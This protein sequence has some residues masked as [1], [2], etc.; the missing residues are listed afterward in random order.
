MKVRTKPRRRAGLI[1]RFKRSDKVAYLLVLP[2]LVQFCVFTAFPIGFAIELTFHSWNL[3]T[4]DKPF[5]GLDNYQYI[6]TVEPH[7]RQSLL[8]LG[9]YVV[10][11]VPGVVVISMLFAI[12]L[13]QDIRFRS[14]FRIVYFLPVVVGGV[15]TL[16]LFRLVLTSQGMLN[17][18]LEF[19][20]V[21]NPPHWFSDPSWA[22]PGFAIIGIWGAF[23]FSTIIFL[24]ALQNI[25]TVLHEAAKMDGARLWQEIRYITVPLLNPTI[26]L[27]VI[28]STIGALQLFAQP[29]ILTGGGPEGSTRT[30][31]I[32]LFWTAFS[33]LEMGRAATIGFLLSLIILTIALIER[34]VL[35]RP[36][37]V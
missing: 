15:G 22:M 28:V 33:Y 1:S 16:L 27:I 9:R 20:G 35:R 37:H 5:V 25:P 14:L 32:V 21:R 3:M 17:S 30:P 2:Y 24:A 36:V 8:N 18:F 7:F 19:V 31:V 29:Y 4:P 26:I 11:Q 6:M 23:G 12:L 10:I 13:N 34:S